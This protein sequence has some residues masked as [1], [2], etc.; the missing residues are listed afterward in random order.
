MLFFYQYLVGAELIA[1][2]GYCH[3]TAQLIL[4]CHRVAC[5]ALLALWPC[6]SPILVPRWTLLYDT[7]GILGELAVG[8]A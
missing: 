2:V 6:V 4:R 7:P 1:W 5:E 8:C 3:L